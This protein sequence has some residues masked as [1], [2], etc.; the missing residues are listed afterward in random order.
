MFSQ[1]QSSLRSRLASAS[2]KQPASTP[3]NTEDDRDREEVLAYASSE[4]PA[5]TPA[6]MEEDSDREEVGETARERL[7]VFAFKATDTT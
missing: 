1:V 2:S 5:S 3:A 6:S 4:Q 7:S